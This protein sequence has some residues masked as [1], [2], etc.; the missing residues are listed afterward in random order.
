MNKTDTIQ[1][2]IET[3]RQV[4][5]KIGLR[6]DVANNA[7]RVALDRLEE[8]ETPT[9][10]KA[11]ESALAICHKIGE[12]WDVAVDALHRLQNELEGE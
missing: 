7:Y 8:R 2:R 10:R 6:I 11:Y 12:E 3:Q 1:N 9:T 5:E 4:V